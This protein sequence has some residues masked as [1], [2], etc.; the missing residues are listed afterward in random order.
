[1]RSLGHHIGIGLLAAGV[2]APALAQAIF[3]CVDAKG[4]RIT[5]DRPIVECLDR[6]Q[7]ELSP[8]GI[9]KRKIGPSL[10]AEERA[11]EEVKQREEIEE[12]NRLAEEKKRERA[13]LTRYPDKQTHDRERAAALA[14]VDEATK[15][16]DEVTRKLIEQRR[17]LDTELEFYQG[18]VKKT[19]ADLRRKIE[20]NRQH[21]E[22]QERFI[23]NQDS[24]KRRINQRFD[25]EQAQLKPLWAQM[26]TSATPAPAPARKKKP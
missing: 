23:A 17:R 20:E 25:D 4:R 12:R 15:I 7:K 1:M 24:E 18:D 3:T 14:A 10:T 2:C 9:V 11:A 21:M 8:T 13:L 19:P 26:A 16:A 5:A 6:E 22:S